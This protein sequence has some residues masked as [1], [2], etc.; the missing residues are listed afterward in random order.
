MRIRNIH[1]D[2][3][4]LP[5]STDQ[6]ILAMVSIGD[7]VVFHYDASSPRDRSALGFLWLVLS[8]ESFNP[9]VVVCEILKIEKDC[10]FGSI[11]GPLQHPPRFFLNIFPV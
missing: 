4:S 7:R 10:A 3:F 2:S 9:I 6:D 5:S 8:S 1:G 11:N